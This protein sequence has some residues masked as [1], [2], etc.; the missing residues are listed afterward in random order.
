MKRFLL[1]VTLC[2]AFAWLAEP[3]S[4]SQHFGARPA[5]Q[6]AVRPVT[7]A[8]QR[9]TPQPGVRPNFPPPSVPRPG[10]VPSRPNV[11]AITRPNLPAAPAIPRPAVVNRPEVSRPDVIRPD[12]P[13]RPGLVNRPGDTRPVIVNRPEVNRPNVVNRP[14]P[15]VGNRV[16]NHNVNVNRWNQHNRQGDAGRPWW[17]RPAYWNRPWYAGRPTWYWGRPYY[18]QH[19]GWHHGYWNYWNKLPAL[20]LGSGV[21]AGWLLSPGDAFVYG[22]PYYVPPAATYAA[23]QYLDYSTPLPAPSA[24]ELADAYPPEPDSAD[25]T[26]AFATTA[27]PAPRADDPAVAAANAALDQARAAFQRGDYAQAQALAE[28]AIASLP[29]DATLHEFRALTLFAQARYKEAAAALYAV[30]AAG[31]GWDWPTMASFYAD[32]ATYTRQLRDL[33]DYVRQHPDD[34]AARFVLAYQYLVQ[35][36]KDAAVTHLRAVV[37]LK[38]EDKLSAALLRALVSGDAAGGPAAPPPAGGG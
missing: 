37:R 9:P 31:P 32:V 12:R 20:W 5:P 6:P 17:D 35:G 18:W 26:T 2:M 11:G 16:I 19:W 23:P 14:N 24:G 22:N 7:P 21:A 30:L 4:A 13:E 33:E 25:E 10:T 3:R 15:N 27:P 34:A 38:P 29:S 8:F 28:Q 36:H 1:A